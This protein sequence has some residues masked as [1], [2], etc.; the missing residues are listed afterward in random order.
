MLLA[1]RSQPCDVWIDDTCVV[2]A[3][4]EEWVDYSVCPI[5][6]FGGNRRCEAPHPASHRA[7]LKPFTP[8]PLP[9]PPSTCAAATAAA[10]AAAVSL[11]MCLMQR[12]MAWQINTIHVMLDPIQ[13][14]SFVKN[15][16]LDPIQ[17]YSLA[18]NM[19]LDRI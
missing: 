14:H 18:I 7:L 19:T 10:A 3:S 8:A 16:M 9:A 15:V 6:G 5:M 2:D 13:H 12:P 1:R 4:D 11:A 17:H